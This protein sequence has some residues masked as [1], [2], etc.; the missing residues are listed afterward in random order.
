M[1][2]KSQRYCTPESTNDPEFKAALPDSSRARSMT[3][4]LTDAT[5]ASNDS[6]SCLQGA[7]ICLHIGPACRPSARWTLRE[8]VC[9][10]A[11]ASLSQWPGLKQ[12]QLLIAAE[13]PPADLAQR[14]ELSH[15]LRRLKREQ[16]APVQMGW[17]YAAGFFDAKGTVYIRHT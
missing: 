10:E 11:A 1:K 6:Q 5:H 15:Q 14:S 4:L 2:N 12:Q 3:S 13:R 17:P 7:Q 16:D 8:V 9:F